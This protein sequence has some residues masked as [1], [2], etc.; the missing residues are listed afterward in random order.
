LTTQ[1]TFDFYSGGFPGP[2]F[3]VQL[4]DHFLCCEETDEKN[5]F[6]SYSV[7]VLNN[8]AWNEM[9]AYLETRKW[10]GDYNLIGSVDGT[11]WELHINLSN[12]NL[13]ASG[14]N[15]FPPGYFKFMKLLNKIFE[16]VG[17]VVC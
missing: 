13:K 6:T 17:V 2:F 14:S 3:R 4:I 9:I 16:E 5:A 7:N 12:I 8:A 15:K 11:Q 10:K 1:N